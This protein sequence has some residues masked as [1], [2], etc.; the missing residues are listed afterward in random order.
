MKKASP[1]VG[2]GATLMK[3]QNFGAGTGAIFMERRAP[4]PVLSEI[5][6]FT[7]YTH[8]LQNE[9]FYISNTLR[10]LMIRAHGLVFW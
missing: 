8:V 3:T 7:P 2:A 9:I 6:D 1:G 10:K 4:E 5:S